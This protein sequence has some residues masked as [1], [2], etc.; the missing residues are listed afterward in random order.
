LTRPIEKLKKKK[1]PSLTDLLIELS[2]PQAESTI[3]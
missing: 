2:S 3:L 1:L